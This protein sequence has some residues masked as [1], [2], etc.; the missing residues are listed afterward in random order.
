[1]HSFLTDL[2]YAFRQM[3]NAPGFATVVIVLIGIGI[4]AN[5]TIFTLVDTLLLRKLPVRNPEE[6]VRIV[7]HHPP[8]PD[9]SYF[10]YSFWQFLRE[11]ATS[12]ADVV[13]QADFTTG[14]TIDGA[15]DF[16]DVGLV[17]ENYFEGLGTKPALGTFLS[18]TN[19]VVLSD[20]YWRKK[21][22]A[23]PHVIGR[24]V[25][26]NNQSFTIVG[27]TA[28]DFHGTTVESNPD[29]RLPAKAAPQLSYELVARLK[30]G[31]SVERALS[32]TVSLYGTWAEEFAKEHPADRA[33]RLKMLGEMQVQPIERG[34]SVLRNQFSSALEL[35]MGGV[36]L[37]LLMVCS[38]VAG[39]LLERATARE[40]ETAVRLAVGASQGRLVRQWLTESLLLAL[41]GGALGVGLAWFTMP[42]LSSMIPPLRNR[43]GEL[44]MLD[45]NFG[46]NWRILLFSFAACVVSAVLAGFAPAWRAGRY[47]LGISLRSSRSSSRVEGGITVFQIAL[48]TLLLVEAGLFVRTL[49]SMR[50]M[51]LGFDRGHVV[52]FTIGPEHSSSEVPATFKEALASEVRQL[53]GVRAAAFARLGLLR[54]TGMKT[55]AGL[56]GE[57]VPASEFMNSSMNAVSPGYFDTMGIR[58][59]A[60]RGLIRTDQ[61]EDFEGSARK[62]PSASP[63]VVNQA[64]ARRFFREQDPIGKSFGTGQGVLKPTHQIVGVASDSQYRSLR[65]AVPPTF[66]SLEDPA[67]SISILHVRAA[68]DPAALINPVREL[69]KKL[70]PGWSIREINL[71]RDEA[72]RSIWRERLVAQLAIGFAVVAGLLAAIGLYG[73]LAYYVSRNRRGIGIRVAIGA[74]R[75]NIV[76]LI[77]G[78][79]VRLIAAGS[80][81]GLAASFALAGWVRALLFGVA[82]SDPVSMGVAVSVLVVIAACA[83]ML[84]AWRATRI[85]PAITLREE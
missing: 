25:G 67:E 23:D 72:E 48:C 84:P 44:L 15:T 71:L 5:A 51:D 65:E 47:D 28:Q 20:R 82:P 66:Y 49:E 57:K 54:G 53:P 24:L 6:L 83:L 35:L 61:P 69:V 26:L 63:V 7:E 45:P 18:T 80:V 59:V 50:S 78:R 8:I 68:G 62:E 11:H 4:A 21:F 1:M 17:T 29:V 60:G 41:L 10:D 64:F 13:G 37:V 52:G 43:A 16:V 75:S 56:P 19:T 30:R 76:E 38:N 27:V 31:V 22:N 42:A 58:I 46:L 33:D 9:S 73:T 34:V 12:Y 74:A 36:V 70:A 32:E 3:R 40:R 77:A 55:S 2:R 79:V 81:L 85:D 39:L 14:M